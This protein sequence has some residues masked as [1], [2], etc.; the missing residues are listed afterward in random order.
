MREKLEVIASWLMLFTIAAGAVWLIIM[1]IVIGW[2]TI[3]NFFFPPT[4]PGDINPDPP[5]G[6]V[7][8]NWNGK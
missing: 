2:V 4:P 6:K 1:P 5:L 3:W 8:R 7:Y